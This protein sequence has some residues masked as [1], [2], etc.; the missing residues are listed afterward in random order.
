MTQDPYTSGQ[1]RSCAGCTLC[2]K[3]PAI[4]EIAKP[5]QTWCKDCAIGTGC[6]IYETRPNTCRKFECVYLT[7]PQ[8]GEHW[9][10]VTSHMVITHLPHVNRVVVHV[11]DEHAG[12]WT[13]EPHYGDIQRMAAAIYPKNGQVIVLDQGVATAVLPDRHKPLGPL[14]DDKVFVTTQTA[15]PNGPVYDVFLY[16]QSDPALETL[17]K[18]TGAVIDR[19]APV[20]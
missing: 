19:T 3:L 4:P 10:P 2:C 5:L 11:D 15:G 17:K 7:S 16:A 18:Q 13:H 9:R 8:L 1:G 14:S 12:V 6:R 20:K